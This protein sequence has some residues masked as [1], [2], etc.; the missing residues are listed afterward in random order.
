MSG[1]KIGKWINDNIVF[2]VGIPLII[3]VHYG[4]LK[5]QENPRLVPPDQRKGLPLVEIFQRGKN[6][7][8]GEGQP[9]SSEK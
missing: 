2:L 8:F 7:L 3:G 6:A 9:T 4:W 1:A 5:L